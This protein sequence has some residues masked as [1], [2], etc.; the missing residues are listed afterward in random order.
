M[1]GDCNSLGPESFGLYWVTGSQCFINSNTV[2]GSKDHPVILVSAATTTRLSGGSN[3]YGV[4]FV[5]DV[6]VP[7]AELESVG[8]NTVYGSVINDAV[9]ASY[10][11]TFQVVWAEDVS[12]KAANSDG[13]G[14]L[15]GGWS[16]F[17][18]AWE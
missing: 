4:L 18:P 7:G 16:D 8:T 17:H 5:T 3:I 15:L 2:V 10:Q 14:S 12:E 1:I 9:L 11:G 6:E 13:L